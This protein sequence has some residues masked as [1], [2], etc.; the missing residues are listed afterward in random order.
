MVS[1]ISNEGLQ[2]AV[3][4]LVRIHLVKEHG[5]KWLNLLNKMSYG[6]NADVKKGR[7]KIYL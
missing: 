7:W 5:D 6:M 4:S 3:E 1:T 2:Y